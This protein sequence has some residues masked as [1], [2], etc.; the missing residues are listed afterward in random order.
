MEEIV[1]V[2]IVFALILIF[3]SLL[4]VIVGWKFE[5]LLSTLRV[6]I[7]LELSSAAGRVS[8]LTNFLIFVLFLVVSVFHEAMA[9]VK[10]LVKSELELSSFNVVSGFT[11]VAMMFLAN[12]VV[13]AVLYG[14]RQ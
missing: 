5:K 1:K 4:S 11:I 7:R 6:V 8:L 13:L 14:K 10:A 3:I 2:A 9:L 12:L